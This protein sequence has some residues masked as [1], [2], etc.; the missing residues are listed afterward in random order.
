MTFLRYTNGVL[1]SAI[2]ENTALVQGIRCEPLG[3]HLIPWTCAVF[4]HIA[5][6]MKDVCIFSHDEVIYSIT[7]IDYS[8]TTA[9]VRYGLIPIYV[10]Y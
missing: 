7:A 3:E 1:V 6:K 2:W 9:G 5:Q 4:S 10:S 8:S